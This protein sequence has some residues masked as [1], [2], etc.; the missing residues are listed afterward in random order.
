MPDHRK[1]RGPHPG[2]ADWFASSEHERLRLACGDLVWLLSRDY[3]LP[4]ALK[5]VGDRYN[6]VQRQRLAVQ[7]SVCSQQQALHRRAKLVPLAS[8]KGQQL[9][10]DGL[11]LITTIEAWLSGGVL[12]LGVDGSVRD[13][14]SVHGTYRQ[15]METQ[16]A[17]ERIGEFLA[18][19]QVGKC[20]WLLDQPVSNSGRLAACMR[21]LAQSRGWP[22]TVELVP[23][24]DRVLSESLEVV[25]SADSVILDR[26]QRWANIAYE[27]LSESGD[28]PAWILDFTTN[29]K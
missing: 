10:L 3:A 2:D 11:N 26:C 12:L 24:P 15:V 20:H 16:E 8:L 28:S 14:A 21:D 7:R 5:L 1:H 29:G 4:S 13:L 19:H 23:D 25:V 27:L 9:Q 22:W 18:F 6:L 17:L